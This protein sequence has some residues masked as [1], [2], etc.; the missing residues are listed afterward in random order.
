MST[1]WLQK[2]Y[3]FLGLPKWDFSAQY[4]VHLENYQDPITCTFKT[5]CWV[6]SVEVILTIF[7]DF[8]RLLFSNWPLAS[9][10]YRAWKPINPLMIPLRFQ[11][12]NVAFVEISIHYD[13]HGIIEYQICW[14]IFPI[15]QANLR[16]KQPKLIV[17]KL[18]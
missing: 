11:S 14:S 16:Q 3:R 1:F 17:T 12:T 9:I 18:F 2:M 6:T 10:N 15:V 7:E 5:E 13:C 8:E 4:K